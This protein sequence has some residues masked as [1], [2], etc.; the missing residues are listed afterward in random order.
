MYV[1]RFVENC[2]ELGLVEWLSLDKQEEYSSCHAKKEDMKIVYLEYTYK[3]YKTYPRVFIFFFFY[4][5]PNV[6][7]R[8]LS[9]FSLVFRKFSMIHSR[10]CE[11]K[12]LRKKSSVPITVDTRV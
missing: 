12:K 3:T 9:I 7:P 10:Y 5:I 6:F 11:E 1:F 8:V 2:V 4:E